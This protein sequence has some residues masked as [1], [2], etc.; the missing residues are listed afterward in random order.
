MD[1][2][3]DG[4][5]TVGEFRSALMRIGMDRGDVTED[6]FMVLAGWDGEM[7]LLELRAIFAEAIAGK[8][9]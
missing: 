7:D 2:D 1:L 9:M 5:I 3:E 4:W 6:M 8:E